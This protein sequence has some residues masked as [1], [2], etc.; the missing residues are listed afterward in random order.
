MTAFAGNNAKSVPECQKP[1]F[2]TFRRIS[3]FRREAAP[4]PPTLLC[5]KR[6]FYPSKMQKC[7][8]EYQIECFIRKKITNSVSHFSFFSMSFLFRE[9]R[10]LGSPQLISDKRRGR[11]QKYSYEGGKIIIYYR[12]YP[13]NLKERFALMTDFAHYILLATN[14][15]S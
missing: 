7:I 5:A 14:F 6:Q 4:G 13:S 12:S 10:G 11:P 3:N 8:K 1:A 2:L 9:E 15:K